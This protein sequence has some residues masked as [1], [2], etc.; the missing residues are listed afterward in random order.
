MAVDCITVLAQSHLDHGLTPQQVAYVLDYVRPTLKGLAVD[1]DAG[2]IKDTVELPTELGTVP[3]GI[4]GPAVGDPPVEEEEVFYAKRG[5]RVA[6]SR[7]V[8]KPHRHQ[9]MVTLIAGPH[10]DFRWALYTIYGGPLAPKEPSTLNRNDT[11]Q[12]HKN[13]REF[14]AVHA[15]SSHIPGEAK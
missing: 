7:L 8:D 6:D 2:L 9:R 12:D 1:D 14:W 13:S 11:A 15:L 10:N 4:Y 3:S 5:D